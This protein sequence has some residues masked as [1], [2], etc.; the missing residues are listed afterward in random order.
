[1]QDL[2][3]FVLWSI[4]G[5]KR[6]P[7]QVY[8][9]AL[10]FSPA[11]SSVRNLFVKERLNWIETGP[12]V[13]GHWSPCLQTLEGHESAVESVSFSDDSR[14]LASASDDRTVKIW[15]TA[16]G[17]LQHTLD[18]H[19]DWVR[20][21]VFS[22]DSRLLA[23]ASDDKTV[24]I[25]V[26]ATGSLQFTLE[27]HDGY[28]MLVVFSH[29]SNYL[30]S[31]SNDRTVKI[32]DTGTG[33][34]QHTLEGHNDWVTSA[35]FSH[36]SC[37][38]AS[39]SDDGTVKIWNTATGS[40]QHTL[41]GHGDHV[42]AVLFSHNSR[43]IASASY[44]RT[45]KIWDTA[46][47]SV[48]HTLEGHDDWVRSAVFSH[49]SR[50]LA[51]ASDDLTV[52]IWHA[53]SGKLHHTFEGFSNMVISLAFSRTASLLASASVDGTVKI[54]DMEIYS[55]QHTFNVDHEIQTMQFD[56]TMSYL[57][58]NVGRIK[59]DATI[60]APGG[61]TS[62][63]QVSD[64]SQAQRQHL[65][66]HGYGLS[67]DLSWITWNG[68]NVLWLPPG[69]KPSISTVSVPSVESETSMIGLGTE[70]GRVVLIRLSSSGPSSDASLILA[71]KCIE[72]LKSE[73]FEASPLLIEPTEE[74]DSIDRKVKSY[75]SQHKFLQYSANNWMKHARDSGTQDS[76]FWEL[77]AKICDPQSKRFQTW[78]R[79]FSYYSEPSVSPAQRF[80]NRL[81]VALHLKLERFI[82]HLLGNDDFRNQDNLWETLAHEAAV[83][84]YDLL[85]DML[86]KQPNW[87]SFVNKKSREKPALLHEA[88]RNGQ[89]RIISTLLDK[90]AKVDEKDKTAKVPLHEA[91]S[92]GHAEVVHLLL[93]QGAKVDENDETGRVPLHDAAAH[94]HNAVIEIL[95]CKGASKALQR[96]KEGKNDAGAKN[97]EAV[98]TVSHGQDFAPPTLQKESDD[99]RYPRLRGGTNIMIRD[100]DNRTPL[101]HAALEGHL[102]SVSLL[103]SRGAWVD[104]DDMNGQ[105]PLYL[106]AI[107]GRLEAAQKLLSEGANF[108]TTDLEGRSISVMLKERL[109]IS[110]EEAK[111]RLAQIGRLFEGLSRSPELYTDPIH[112]SENT[113]SQFSCAIIDFASGISQRHGKAREPRIDKI[114]SG[115]KDIFK[116]GMEENSAQFRWLHLPANNVSPTTSDDSSV[117]NPSDARCDGLR[118]VP[119][120]SSYVIH[121]LIVCHSY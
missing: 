61:I 85:L 44:D 117:T 74:R 50:L 109:D 99:Q 56:E 101:H 98:V 17:S 107:N 69:Y 105:T 79:V 60:K 71:R 81:S 37:L 25:W 13:E 108:R 8:P 27:G 93:D 10:V 91:A 90:G 87:D 15:D 67:R 36:D 2:Y 55:L 51:S 39:A 11:H 22:H 111:E 24:K 26:V 113:D 72:Y 38:L 58:T 31:A 103:L 92:N 30:A 48:Q 9:S 35:V 23:S 6:A 49:D 45:V 46:T 7:L 1:M 112:G 116:Q 42:I 63:S 66:R 95:L 94:G 34:L 3:R 28:V 32:W 4:S 88:A 100:K 77:A 29:D 89:K 119:E 84:G 19:N 80:P 14:L 43:I 53:A 86:V 110:D 83:N 70:S 33:S 97:V 78:L 120:N 104:V 102:R 59:L 62:P 5:I 76:R 16:T 41:D 64:P 114:I 18:G 75:V 12:I 73:K 115:Q 106:A 121:V 68:D 21:A 82:L 65:Q 47:G 96:N 118:H 57:D 52:R 54:W 40:L 20:S